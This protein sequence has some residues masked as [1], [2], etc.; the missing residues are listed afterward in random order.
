MASIAMM[1]VSVIFAFFRVSSRKATTPLL[2]ASTPAIA[3]Q[4]EEK[5]FS[6]SH[7][8]I[9]SVAAGIAGSGVTR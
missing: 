2:T 8:L 5:T 9:A 3:V 6:I 4:P 7:R 1:M